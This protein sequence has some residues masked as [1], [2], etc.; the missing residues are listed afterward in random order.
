VV[1][2]H[3]WSVSTRHMGDGW[4]PSVTAEGDLRAKITNVAC[5][6]LQTTDL[7]FDTLLPICRSF[8]YLLY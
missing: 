5:K 8:V 2:S 6:V 4:M 3:C 1:I 7:S